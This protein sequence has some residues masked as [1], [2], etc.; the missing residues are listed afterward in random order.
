MQVQ[1]GLGGIYAY[2][3]YTASTISFVEGGA[4]P[5][6][7]E[8]SASGFLTAGF[9]VGMSIAITDTASNN[10]TVT[11]NGLTA[12]RI[13]LLASDD[14]TDEAEGSATLA[15][16]AYGTQLIGFRQWGGVDG[17]ELVEKTC[18][19]NY[20]YRRF[21]TTLKNWTANFE[22]F[23]LS[24]ERDSLLGRTLHLRLFQRFALD[25]SATDMAIFWSGDGI[26]GDIPEDVPVDALVS[27]SFSVQGDGVLT[28]TYKTDAW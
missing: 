25:P 22:G 14:L 17:I 10:K 27:Q 21:A 18:F 12:S 11:I 8:D 4:S 7:I 9:V 6:Y 1:G 19:E 5:D 28:K 20:P 16:P 23:W 26:I 15:T 13:T 2:A 24:I 3:T